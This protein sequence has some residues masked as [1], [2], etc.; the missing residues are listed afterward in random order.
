M[1]LTDQPFCQ[2]VK[3]NI[4]VGTNKGFHTGFFPGGGNVDACKGCMHMS[5]HLVVF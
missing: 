2:A 4:N 3:K 5:V 1:Q